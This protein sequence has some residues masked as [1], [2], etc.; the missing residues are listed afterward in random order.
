MEYAETALSWTDIARVD[1][2]GA[3]V[4][5]VDDNDGIRSRLKKVVQIL[6]YTVKTAASAEEAD[7]W[8]EAE[9]F[10]VILLDI[11]LPRMSGVE[12][13]RW[14]LTK[15]PEVAVIMLTGL[16]N[17]ELALE[18]LHAGARTY[19]VKP[20]DPDF[21]EHALRDAVAMGRLLRDRNRLLAA[22]CR[23]A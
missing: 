23:S 15:D 1:P 21:I 7:R 4:L 10:D 8:M 9:P 12:F 5:I 22:S 14:A 13:L 3:A 18:C 6:G 11:E 16:D 20:F 17:P 19:F 2:S